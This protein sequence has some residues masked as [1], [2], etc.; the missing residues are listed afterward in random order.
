MAHNT[1][2]TELSIVKA[3]DI[4]LAYDAFGNPD[5]MP[6]LLIMG[7]G[8]Q[9]IAW[10]D[11]FCSQLSD[12]GFRV[13]RFDNRDMGLSSSLD[14]LGVPRIGKLLKKLVAGA[15]VTAPYLLQDMADDAINLMDVLNIGAAHVVGASMGGMIAQA[16]CLHYPERVKTLTSIMSTTGD[17]DLPPPTPAAMEV[18]M[19]P[20][21]PDR[22]G[23]I[24]RAVIVARTLSGPGYPSDDGLAREMAALS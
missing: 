21:P 20:Y 13:I 17:P 1:L 9:M 24:E 16:V 18:L 14:P 3:G 10:D 4:K 11:A 22:Q 19:T 8:A 23:Y 6:M 5:A 7:L 2:H 12:R 15:P